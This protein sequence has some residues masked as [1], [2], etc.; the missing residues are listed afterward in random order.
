MGFA[1]LQSMLDEDY[2]DGL[3]YYWKSVFLEDLTDEVV[4]LLARYNE[5]AP[6]ELSTVDVWH[7]GGAV[8]DVPQ[9]ATAF[10]H[11]DKPF[12]L[13]FEA[14]WGDAADDDANVAW[15]REGLAEI[16]ALP[17]A[18]GRYGNF[19]GFG[20]DPATA[21]FGENYERLVDVKTKYDPDNLFHLNQN[22]APRTAE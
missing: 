11:R 17:A 19:P 5:S 20:E 18:A 21:L 3:R 13:N 16:A 12:M 15:A 8:S 2:P 22:V 4:D 6:S 10:W 7:L 9:T 14:N 1:E